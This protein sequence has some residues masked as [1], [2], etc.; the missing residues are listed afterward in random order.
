MDLWTV[1]EGHCSHSPARV[2]TVESGLYQSFD[3]KEFNILLFLLQGVS[4][5]RTYEVDVLLRSLPQRL[6]TVNLETWPMGDI[7]APELHWLGMLGFG[8]KL[9]ISLRMRDSLNMFEPFGHPYAPFM[10]P[11]IFFRFS[12]SLWGRKLSGLGSGALAFFGETNGW[13]I[14]GEEDESEGTH[15]VWGYFL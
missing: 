7:Q 4:G 3:G 1:S 14:K 11:A 6:K 10:S 12:L 9:W 13:K 2:K 15:M 5:R 8:P